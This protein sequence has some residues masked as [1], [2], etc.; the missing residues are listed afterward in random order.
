MPR[1]GLI[2]VA[3]LA[4]VLGAGPVHAQAKPPAVAASGK[5]LLDNDRVRV[6]EVR[7]QPGAKLELPTEANQFAYLLTD[8]ALVFSRPGHT[9]Y[10][11]DFKAGEATLLPAQSTHAQNG[12]SK[13]VRAVLVVLKDGK[14]ASSRPTKTQAN[15]PRSVKRRRK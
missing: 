7:L 12:S 4:I 11:L 3:L 13:E 10:E 5:V 8:A 9:P 6:S 14:R 15:K 2:A 1:F